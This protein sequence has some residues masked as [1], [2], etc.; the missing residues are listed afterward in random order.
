MSKRSNRKPD[1]YQETA[2]L[3]QESRQLREQMS[4]KVEE[5]RSELER[6][7]LNVIEAGDKPDSFY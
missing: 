4:I 3:V 1:L 5:L 7:R 2:A 6:S